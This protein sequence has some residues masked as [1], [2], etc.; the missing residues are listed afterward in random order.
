MKLKLKYPLPV[1]HKTVEEL[2]FRDYTT[3]AD[4]LAFDTR[5]GVA[6]Q[7]ALIANLTGTD[8]VLIKRLHGADYLAAVKASDAL[9]EAD[10]Q[11]FKDAGG[12]EG[13]DAQKKS[14]ES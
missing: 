5:G 6:Q 12:E 2:T 13:D 9:L 1:G 11:L 10:Q 8:E 3:A 4:Y 7:I 14:S